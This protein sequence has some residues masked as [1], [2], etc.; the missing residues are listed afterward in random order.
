MSKS[1]DPFPLS[2]SPQVSRLISLASAL[3]LPWVSRALPTSHSL[4]QG[5]AHDLLCPGFPLALPLLWVA[6]LGRGWQ[7]DAAPQPGSALCRQEPEESC[8]LQLPQNWE[9]LVEEHLTLKQE[10]GERGPGQG[11]LSRGRGEP[12]VLWGS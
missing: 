9:E 3:P 11:R 1:P 5:P 4:P 2:I 12:S 10:E 7:L 6:A 8:P